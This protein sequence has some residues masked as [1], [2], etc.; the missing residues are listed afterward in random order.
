MMSGGE[1]TG[2]EDTGGDTT[3]GVWARTAAP[4][5]SSDAAV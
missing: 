2:G 3:G 1:D 5:R 4:I